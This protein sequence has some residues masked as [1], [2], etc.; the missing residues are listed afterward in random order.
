MCI[1]D[2]YKD[3]VNS[4]IE[5]AK[6]ENIGI[7]KRDIQLRTDIKRNLDNFSSRLCPLEVFII[8]KGKRK[9]K[10]EFLSSIE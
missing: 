4:N 9:S 5:I 3:A 2:R 1:R 6:R 7:R 10:L 8:T